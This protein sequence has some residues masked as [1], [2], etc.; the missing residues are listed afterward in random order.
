MYGGLSQVSRRGM[1]YIDGME[2]RQ[3]AEQVL[4]GTRWEDKLV[5]LD[6]LRGP[7]ARGGD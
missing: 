5:A 3:F 4:F 2:I 7:R 6:L 1:R